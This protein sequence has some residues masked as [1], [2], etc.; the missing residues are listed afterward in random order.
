VITD[1][2]DQ[3]NVVPSSASVWYYFRELTY[4][5]IVKLRGIGDRMAQGAAMMTD[6]EVTSRVLGAA[7]PRHFNKVVAEVVQSHIEAVGMPEWSDS[8][9]TLAR[10]V[11]AELDSEERGGLETEIEP[12][13]E[14]PET[15][16]SGGSDDIGDISWKVPTVTLAFPA[17][18]PDL[19]GHHWANAIAMATPIAHKGA[20]AGAMV[21]A[22]SVLDFLV[23]PELVEQAWTYYREVQTKDQ[24]YQPLIS[25][26]DPP[27][28]HLNSGTMATYREQQR[29]F[30]Y[31]PARFD[32]YLEQLGIE[33]PTI[34]ESSKPADEDQRP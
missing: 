1:G 4:P 30:Y 23:R 5:E 24:Q 32:T 27:P 18:I 11:Q 3:P 25:A 28:V 31:D 19:P 7:W 20:T 21:V 16:E 6:T 2:G 34:R 15:P 26:D 29:P 13:K 12:L 8:D 10:A 17:N 22:R 9:Q 14:P 33:Y